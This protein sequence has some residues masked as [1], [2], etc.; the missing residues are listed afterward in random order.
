VN[1]GPNEKVL[2][3]YVPSKWTFLGNYI[4]VIR[5]CWPLKY[6]HALEIDQSLLAHTPNEDG[7]FQQILR[8]NRLGLGSVPY[9]EL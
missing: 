2:D 5:G 9:F 4:S 7:D 1:F 6:L 8:V 3:A